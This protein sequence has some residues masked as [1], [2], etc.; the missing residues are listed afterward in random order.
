MRK[1]HI[2]KGRVLSASGE[3]Q[4]RREHFYLFAGVSVKALKRG[5]SS[6]SSFNYIFR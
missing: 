6:S 1:K 3:M 2:S 5:R 4:L